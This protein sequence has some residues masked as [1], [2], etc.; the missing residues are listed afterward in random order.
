MGKD[1]AG[2]T[3]KPPPSTGAHIPSADAGPSAGARP[4]SVVGIEVIE[5]EIAGLAALRDA[6]RGAGGSLGAAFAAAVAVCEGVEGR[7]IVTGMGKSGHVARK[8]AA[9]LASTGAPASFVHPGEASHG[10][11]GMIGRRDAIL[12]LS[13]SG[14]TPELRDVLAYAG[15]FS[16][17]LIAITAGTESTLA[18]AAD[19]RLI[20]PGAPEACDVT[21]A[22]TTS[23]T[24]MLALGDAL[25]VAVLRSKGFT[26]DDFYQ[27][28]PGGKLGAALK[29]VG[30]LMH[31]KEMP[32]C[33]PDDSV[34]R[35]VSVITGAGFG[36][37]GVID[38]DGRLAGMITDGDLRRHFSRSLKGARA[39]D[40]MTPDPLVVREDSLAAEALSLL[41]KRKITA[42]FIV[43]EARRPLGLLHVH[44]CLSV[45]V[46]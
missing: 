24:M 41:S 39:A 45:G 27:F 43:D 46:V 18:R 12:A 25:A 32:L 33:G 2:T 9:T 19:I 35:A 11:L 30:D 42:L 1:A 14:E 4:S 7:L 3:S 29:R 44:D 13:N 37:V 36:C 28:H 6:M 21:N 15:R 40:V 16:I 5:T 26:A 34:E 23:T 20:V 17:P 38:K 31:H 22:P 10:D 8:I